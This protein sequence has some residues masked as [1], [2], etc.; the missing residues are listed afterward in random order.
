MARRRPEAEL[1]EAVA[2][3]LNF[4]L[5]AGAVFH[6]SPNEGRRGWQAQ[7]DL[8]KQGVRAG[9]PDLEV[10][11]QGQVYFI[12]LKADKKKPSEVQLETHTSLRNAGFQVDV[13]RSQGEVYIFL[14][15][16]IPLKARPL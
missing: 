6:H 15:P 13:C 9:W 16:W 10:G 4:A 14:A 5:P 8:K 11:Y 1:H 7:R 12:E 2:S 3:Y